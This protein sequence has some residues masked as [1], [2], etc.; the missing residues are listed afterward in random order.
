MARSKSRSGSSRRGAAA[1]VAEVEVVSEES[2]MGFE[3]GLAIITTIILLAAVLM[4]D[5]DRGAHYGEG[6]L[7]KDKYAAN[8]SSASE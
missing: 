8:A 5:Y 3:A 1:E 4:I 7:F 6:M 2:G